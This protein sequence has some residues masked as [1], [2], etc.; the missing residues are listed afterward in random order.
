MP[1]VTTRI[2]QTF[3][4]PSIAESYGPF[5]TLQAAMTYVENADIKCAGLTVGIDQQDGSVKEYWLQPVEGQ[6]QFVEKQEAGQAGT[7]AYVHIKYAAALPASAQDMH[8]N[9]TDGDKYI[10]VYSGDSAIAPATVNSYQWAKFVGALWW[11]WNYHHNESRGGRG[12]TRK[13]IEKA[14]YSVLRNYEDGD[15]WFDYCDGEFVLNT[16]KKTFKDVTFKS[17]FR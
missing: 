9:Y 3:K 7:N 8:N 1:T 11:F 5:A 15:I 2:A 14:G 12:N 4:K 13:K 17:R 6:L 16:S 10:G